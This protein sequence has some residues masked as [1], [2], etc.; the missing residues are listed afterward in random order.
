[1]IYQIVHEESDEEQKNRIGDVVYCC[2]GKHEAPKDDCRR[3]KN[4][5]WVCER[6]QEHSR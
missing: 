1:M 5:D 2:V 6:C 3:A 4:G